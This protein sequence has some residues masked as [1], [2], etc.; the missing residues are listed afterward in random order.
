MLLLLLFVKKCLSHPKPSSNVILAV[1][2]FFLKLIK[3]F[4]YS[5]AS[6]CSKLSKNPVSNSFTFSFA[7]SKLTSFLSNDFSSL[8][9]LSF[10]FGHRQ[11]LELRL[12]DL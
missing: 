5:S 8:L 11:E 7:V 10:D 1:L 2:I 3:V 9:L 6:L 12:K 4:L